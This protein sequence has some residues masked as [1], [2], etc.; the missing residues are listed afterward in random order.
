MP[1]TP[2]S[3]FALG[4]TLGIFDFPRA[5]KIA[6]ARFSVGIGMG[7]QIERALANFM[8]DLHVQEH[9]YT[10]VLLPVLVNRTSMTGT[11]CPSVAQIVESK[12]L[13]PC[14]L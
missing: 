9:G 5:T 10:E 4:E 13:D 1:F 6:G 12:P 14:T 11:G 2:R 7:A 3:H 8:I